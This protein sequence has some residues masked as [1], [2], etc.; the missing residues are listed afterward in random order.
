MSLTL[1]KA[2][3]MPPLPLAL[4][5]LGLAACSMDPAALGITGPGQQVVAAPPSPSDQGQQTMPG[6][7]TTGTFYGPTNGGPKTGSSGFWNYNN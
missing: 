5:L 2:L 7:A 1:R 4:C 6:V 3:S